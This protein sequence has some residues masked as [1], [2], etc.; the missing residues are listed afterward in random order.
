MN[1]RRVENLKK[2]IRVKIHGTCVNS[3]WLKIR[4]NE[5]LFLSSGVSELLNRKV[6]KVGRSVIVKDVF[7]SA[8]N[9]LVSRNVGE[10]YV[11]S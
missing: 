7:N 4:D 8:R 11:H 9:I 6:I 5:T 2:C 3:I 10:V 1:V